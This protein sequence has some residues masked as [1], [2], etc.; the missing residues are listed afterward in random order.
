MNILIPKYP[1]D[2]IFELHLCNCV[3][4]FNNQLIARNVFSLLIFHIINGKYLCCYNENE[5]E[6]LYMMLPSNLQEIY[7]SQTTGIIFCTPAE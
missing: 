5:K 2:F 4:Y 6:I 3:L 7:I 1:S